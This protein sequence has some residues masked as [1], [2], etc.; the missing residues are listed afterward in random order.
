[1]AFFAEDVHLLACV[2]VEGRLFVCKISEGPDEEGT[3]Q[4]TGIV[5]AIQIIGEGEDVHPRVWRHCHKHEVLV[6]WVGKRFYK[7]LLLKLQRVK[8]LLLRILL[9]FL[10]KNLL[11]GSNLLVNMMEVT[12]LSM[13]QWMTT[14]LVSASMDG[15]IKIWEDRKSQPL[16]VL[17]C[18]DGFPVYSS[19]FVTAPNRPRSHHAYNSGPT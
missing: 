12:D 1:M 15:T 16:L 18:Y 9:S 10:L 4:I 19:T 8:S 7:L 14:R 6:V 2:S 17:R 3:P 13:C 11:M 5:M